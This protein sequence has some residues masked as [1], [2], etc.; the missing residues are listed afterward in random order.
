[1][2]DKFNCTLSLN[3][4]DCAG[5]YCLALPEVDFPITTQESL[6]ADEIRKERR[7]EEQK[8]IKALM[9]NLNSLM[10][11]LTTTRPEIDMA[12]LL[13]ISDD[14]ST[15]PLILNAVY[16]GDEILYQEPTTLIFETLWYNQDLDA[17]KDDKRLFIRW[18]SLV[19]F[20]TSMREWFLAK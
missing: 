9:L 20:M 19:D 10:F 17:L 14:D 16:D 12:I 4:S 8:Q 13:M 1:M 3:C 6:A 7:I 5:L 2:K 15:E 11:D 18:I